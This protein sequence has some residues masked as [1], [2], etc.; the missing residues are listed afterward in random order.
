MSGP[1]LRQMASAYI[2]TP[3]VHHTHTHLRA[4][5]HS[6]RFMATSRNPIGERIELPEVTVIF[7][8]AMALTQE[9]IIQLSKNKEGRKLLEKASNALFD[10]LQE[11]EAYQAVFTH[12][13]GSYNHA[14]WASPQS[15]VSGE[16]NYQAQI[17]KSTKDFDEQYIK[18]IQE[19]RH[20]IATHMPD[21]GCAVM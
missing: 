1:L 21:D 10:R 12:S 15:L 5:N 3:Q 2:R 13:N 8:N 20:R 11:L 9:E 16:G 7:T 18:P 14:R 4:M 17:V 19:Q 6:V